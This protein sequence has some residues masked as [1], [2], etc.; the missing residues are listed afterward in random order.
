MLEDPHP[1]SPGRP[2]ARQPQ[3]CQVW[4]AAPPPRCAGASQR[5]AP[6]VACVSECVSMRRAGPRA[7]ASC[8]LMVTP[9]PVAPPRQPPELQLYLPS[10]PTP[11]PREAPGRIKAAAAGVTRAQWQDGVPGDSVGWK[12]SG[13]DAS[14][15]HPTI[16]LEKLLSSPSPPCREPPQSPL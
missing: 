1:S 13:H 14:S 12:I 11:I 5:G 9:T 16:V 15:S 3:A 10:P 2:A 8:M 6:G 7:W 4:A